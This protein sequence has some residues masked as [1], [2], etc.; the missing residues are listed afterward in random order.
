MSRFEKHGGMI[1]LFDAS[2][3]A[4]AL[5]KAYESRNEPVPVM[6]FPWDLSLLCKTIDAK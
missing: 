3:F 2:D 4:R 6:E 5:Q 1:A